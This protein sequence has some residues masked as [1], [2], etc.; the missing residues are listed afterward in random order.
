L[1]VILVET[2]QEGALLA[3]HLIARQVRLRPDSVLGLA[4]GA[5]PIPIYAELV[6]MHREEGLSFRR[7]STFNLDEYVGLASDHPA[8]YRRYMQEHLF[9]RVDLAPE[10]THVPDGLAQD[11]PACCTRYE[12]LIRMAGGVDLQLLGLGQ[13]G[14]IGFNE[15]SSSLASRTRLKTLTPHTVAANRPGFPP[16]E[17][18][19]QG[20]G[21]GSDGG[22][23]A[24]RHGSRLDPADASV[25]HDPRR[26]GC[27]PALEDAQILS[28][29]LSPQAGLA[30]GVTWR[31]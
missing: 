7:V 28:G 23:A 1:E 11:I 2:G 26:R 12:E 19:P 10:R 24:D 22:G 3:A 8:S 29:R 20:I 27:R 31:P 9:G 4:T 6:R 13:D 25:R 21:C 14:H 18:V 30:E 5:T 17:A 15:P 16:G